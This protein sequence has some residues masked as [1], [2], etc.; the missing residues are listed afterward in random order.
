[1]AKVKYLKRNQ[2]NRGVEFTR[3]ITPHLQSKIKKYLSKKIVFSKCPCLEEN[4]NLLVIRPNVCS[5]F[6]PFAR[7]K[8]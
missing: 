1:M 3:S 4:K 8:N 2:S 6:I 7:G 5:T